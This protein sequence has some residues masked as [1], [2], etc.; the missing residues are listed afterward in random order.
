MGSPFHKK[1]GMNVEHGKGSKS[2]LSVGKPS[3]K[4]CNTCRVTENILPTIASVIKTV[5]FA[6]D[7]KQPVAYPGFFYGGVQ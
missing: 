4:E 7:T 3:S 5:P 1:C 2:C 6:T